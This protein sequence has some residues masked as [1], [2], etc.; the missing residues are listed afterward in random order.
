MFLIPQEGSIKSSMLS[1]QSRTL[2]HRSLLDME[3]E[4]LSLLWKD[5]ILSCQS[6]HP[7]VIRF[8]KLMIISIQLCLVCLPMEINWLIRW[9]SLVRTICTCMTPQSLLNNL[10]R[11]S[12]RLSKPILSKVEWDLMVL[13]S[14]TLVGMNIIS[15]RSLLATQQEI[16]RHGEQLL[17]DRTKMPIIIIFKRNIKKDWTD[18]K[19]WVFW[20]RPSILQMNKVLLK[21]TRL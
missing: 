9:D 15:S 10:W 4:L 5:L 20:S 13:P 21:L 8:S 2:L 12:A 17:R 18:N 11:K 14:F 7:M 3:T 1:W 16:Y 6:I 19:P